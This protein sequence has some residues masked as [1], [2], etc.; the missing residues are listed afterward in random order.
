MSLDSDED[1]GITVSTEA[2]IE[3]LEPEPP[4]VLDE[5]PETKHPEEEIRVTRL[6]LDEEKPRQ[7][8]FEFTNSFFDEMQNDQM[9]EDIRQQEEPD[10]L[11]FEIRKVE[12]TEDDEPELEVPCKNGTSQ[13]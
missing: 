11:Q 5:A 8:S 6:Q 3:E 7:F 10:S 12:D 9:D 13:T 2:I 4:V 1:A